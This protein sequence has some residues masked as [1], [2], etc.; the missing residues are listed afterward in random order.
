MRRVFLVFTLFILLI[1]ACTAVA[2]PTA[3]ASTLAI[4]RPIR[5]FER[6]NSRCCPSRTGRR[7]RDQTTR[8]EPGLEGK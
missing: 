8:R 3:E 4:T 6:S 7:N 1:A 5:P 2:A